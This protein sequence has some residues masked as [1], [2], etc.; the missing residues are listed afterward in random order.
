MH[1]LDRRML[2]GAAA[3]ATALAPTEQA[4]RAR[5]VFLDH[6]ATD[7]TLV[8]SYHL[9]FPGFAHVV[10]EGSGYRWPPADWQ[11]TS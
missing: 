7:K 4:T 1:T 8:G 6:A 10:R 3:G 11:W 2:L 5:L 9:P